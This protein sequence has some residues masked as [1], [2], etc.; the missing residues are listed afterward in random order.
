V[1]DW[2]K[3]VRAGLKRRGWSQAELARRSKV[4]PPWLN[5]WLRTDRGISGAVLARLI[6]ALEGG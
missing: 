6:D 3:Q 1:K 2:R 5:R 4:T